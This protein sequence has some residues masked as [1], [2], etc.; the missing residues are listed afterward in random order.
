M[1][2]IFTMWVL[3]ICMVAFA[4]Q[5]RERGSDYC[6]GFVDGYERGWCY[7]KGEACFSPPAPVCPVPEVNED[8]TYQG[9]YDRGFTQGLNDR[10]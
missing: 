3:L 4:S 7:Q 1:R 9:G 2:A 6:E 8:Y 10:K 5:V